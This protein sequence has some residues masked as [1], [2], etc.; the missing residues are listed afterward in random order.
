MSILAP[1]ISIQHC[2]RGTRLEEANGKWLVEMKK[3]CLCNWYDYPNQIFKFNLYGKLKCSKRLLSA[4]LHWMLYCIYHFFFLKIGP[5]L[6]S[7][8]NLLFVLL[9]L[10][11]APR[12]IVIY[13]SCRSFWLCYVGHCLSMAW[14]AVPCPHPWSELV[15]PWATKAK[16]A[17]LTTRPWGW[18]R[19]LLFKTENTFE[20]FWWPFLQN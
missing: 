2:I 5:E 12:Y 8:A 1:T 18:P 15:K 9:L 10:P 4:I 19:Y 11:K 13:S 14:R 6:T 17:H 16:H 20:I 7:V 3:L